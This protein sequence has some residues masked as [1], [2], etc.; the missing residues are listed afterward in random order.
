MRKG[1]TIGEVMD[2]VNRR[3]APGWGEIISPRFVNEIR[4]QAA[5]RFDLLSQSELAILDLV[6]A[7]HTHRTTDEL[8]QW[9]HDNCSEYEQVASNG[10]KPIEVESILRA[11]KKSPKTIRTV[12][13]NAIEIEEMDALL[14]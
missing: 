1:P 8:V 4:L 7:Q 3:N 12:L 2:F 14:R 10:R 13:N 5:P 6:V 11:A 9:C